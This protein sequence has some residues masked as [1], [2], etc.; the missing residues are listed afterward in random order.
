MPTFLGG[1]NH[2]VIV[3]KLEL[4]VLNAFSTVD[5][6]TGIRHC[7]AD[8]LPNILSHHISFEE[9]LISKQAHA[10]DTAGTN[11]NR[12]IANLFLWSPITAYFV[13][14]TPNLSY[15]SEN[16]SSGTAT[17][18]SNAAALVLMVFLLKSMVWI[19]IKLDV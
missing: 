18:N 2:H 7:S 3:A 5:L 14:I 16:Y 6:F 4:I 11:R 13:Q 12:H 1:I 9:G 8:I 15:N 19:K 10:M 17:H